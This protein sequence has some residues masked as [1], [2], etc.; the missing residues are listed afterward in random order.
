[1]DHLVIG[2][3]EP[4]EHVPYYGKYVNLVNGQDILKSFAIQIEGTL[5]FLRAIPESKNLHR[6]APGK[7]SVNE[8]VGHVLDAERVFAYRALT[9]ARNDR[10]PLPGFEQDDWVRGSTFDRQPLAELISEFEHVRLSNIYFFTHLTQEAWMRRGT[11]NTA[12]ITV[13]ALAYII[14][15]HELH[16]MQILRTNYLQP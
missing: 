12:E 3:P 2:K 8:V 5:A 15:G 7:W 9:I 10:T 4:S 1:M 6:Y 11:V 14:A 13:R 16:H